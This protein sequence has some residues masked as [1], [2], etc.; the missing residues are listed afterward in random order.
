MIRTL[1]KIFPKFLNFEQIQLRMDIAQEMLTAFTDDPDLPKKLRNEIAMEVSRPKK[2]RK[3]RSNVEIFILKCL[4]DCKNRWQKY[5]LSNGG[6][7]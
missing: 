4:E 6:F 5:I 2:A 1:T 3:V 7:L